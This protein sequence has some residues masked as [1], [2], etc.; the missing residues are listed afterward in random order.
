[1]RQDRLER[2]VLRD[3]GVEGLLAAEARGDLQRLAAVVAER[4]EDVDQELAVR[5]RVADLEGRV[6]GGEHVQVM[7]VE[8]G[9]GLRVVRRELVFGD[10]VDP[11]AHELTEQ[12]TARLAP[13][14]LG[15]DSDGVL[16]LDE[17]EGHCSSRG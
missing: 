11:S 6:P 7:L 9:D 8:I 3:A 16:G 12:L 13:D 14:G 15:D 4:A 17:A 5:D 1:V 2:L 10:L